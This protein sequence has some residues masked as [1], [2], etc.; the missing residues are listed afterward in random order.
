MLKALKREAIAYMVDENSY[1]PKFP[2]IKPGDGV[3]D[4]SYKEYDLDGYVIDTVGV[5]SAYSSG[6]IEVAI[7]D[8]ECSTNIIKDYEKITGIKMNNEDL[9]S[10]IHNSFIP[11]EQNKIWFKNIKQFIDENE[12]ELT[13]ESD[14]EIEADICDMY[15]MIENHNYLEQ[16]ELR[17]IMS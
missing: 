14:V 17:R 10:S 16:K 12:I 4:I 3:I 7:Y 2:I 9:F 1:D 5:I 11:K 6:V 15:Q 8:E 13:Y